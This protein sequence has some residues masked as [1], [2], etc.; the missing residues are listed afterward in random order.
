MTIARRSRGA[1]ALAAVVLVTVAG[2]PS[3]PVGAAAL[4]PFARSAASH[5]PLLAHDATPEPTDGSANDDSGKRNKKKSK[6]DAAPD[7]ADSADN[8]APSEAE[9][10][11][12]E[13]QNTAAADPAPA[14]P[15]PVAAES[16]PAGPSASTGA[17]EADQSAPAAET[18][19]ATAPE[20][21]PTETSS[22]AAPAAD[23]TT[24]EPAATDPA[25]STVE[26][27]PAPSDAPADTPPATAA[28]AP[29]A[30]TPDPAPT[31]PAAAP[32][33]TSDAP[34]AIGTVWIVGSEG[35]ACHASMDVTSPVV[36]VFPEGTEVDVVGKTVG[37][38]Q[39]VAC[40]GQT[41]Y[42][43]ASS[44]SWWPPAD[45]ATATPAASAPTSDATPTA[46]NGDK[47]PAADAN[48]GK[49]I[50]DVAMQ[51]VGYPYVHAAEGPDAF[52][53]SG[54]TMFV[55]RQALGLNLTHDM[56]VQWDMG[57]KLDRDQLQPGDLV[58][59][60]NTIEPGLSHVGI[61]IGNGEFVHAENEQTGVVVSDLA[62][63]YY[64]AHWFGAVRYP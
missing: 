13:P 53:C 42:L 14:D 20:P 8:T 21:T 28:D 1:L 44:I 47:T 6:G 26:P 23:A 32:A 22:D 12:G 11:A 58:F 38:W 57:T 25:A 18:P 35:A 54:F 16:E 59:F 3:Q 48:P 34:G 64:A 37:D 52:D 39:P 30:P 7:A 51:Y 27:A 45:D 46:A 10:T 31:E 9:P 41:G 40:N 61:Y 63:D 15:E 2:G 17:T 29:A 43:R 49:A 19:D 62:S 60:Q 50:V 55:V 5:P 56:V 24:A 4:D 33:P 36:A